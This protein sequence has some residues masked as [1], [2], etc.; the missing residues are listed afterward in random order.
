MQK[1]KEKVTA[2]AAATNERKKK[3][4]DLLI[5]FVGTYGKEMIREFFD[6][7][8]EPN[9]SGSHMRYEL[10]RTWDLNLRLKTWARRDKPPRGRGTNPSVGVVLHNTD[11]DYEKTRK[12]LW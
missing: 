6:Y 11:E 8:S 10:E 12:Q 3:F 5:P 2:A 7:W 1:E 4:Y 9:R